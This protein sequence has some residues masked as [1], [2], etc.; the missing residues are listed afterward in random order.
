VFWH[1]MELAEKDMS[2][3]SLL[4]VIPATCIYEIDP[5][6]QSY[7]ALLNWWLDQN[8]HGRHVYTGNFASAIITKHW[9]NTEI[10]RQVHPIT[11]TVSIIVKLISLL[12]IPILLTDT[13]T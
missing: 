10:E 11:G 8:T 13:K 12:W 9:S 5:P 3:K 2:T 7:P 6:V 4:G 1:L